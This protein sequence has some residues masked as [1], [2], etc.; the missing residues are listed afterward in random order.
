MKLLNARVKKL[1]KIKK[2]PA[3]FGYNEFFKK[4]ID[5]VDGATRGIPSE[6]RYQTPK[7]IEQQNKLFA[8]YPEYAT[9]FQQWM[10]ELE[11]Q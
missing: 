6:H 1:E 4:C 8:D 7:Q 9:K 10:S 3:K 11:N 5:L 2:K